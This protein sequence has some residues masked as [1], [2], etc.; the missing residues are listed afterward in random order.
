MEGFETL[1]FQV[2]NGLS[3]SVWY[4]TITKRGCRAR[5]FIFSFQRFFGRHFDLV[6]QN[7]DMPKCNILMAENKENLAILG[8]KIVEKSPN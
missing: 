5:N 7:L 6:F 3:V 2:V 4:A 1:Q 8:R